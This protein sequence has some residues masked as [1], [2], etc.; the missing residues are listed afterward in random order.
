MAPP[1]PPE[2]SPEP[3][4]NRKSKSCDNDAP[5]LNGYVFHRVIKN[6]MIQAGGG[7]SNPG[8]CLTPTPTLVHRRL[9]HNEPF[10][11]SSASTTQFFVTTVKA[12]HLDGVHTV[13]GRLLSGKSVVRRIEH[14]P[15]GPWD[16]PLQRI[17]VA[18]CG[19]VPATK[20]WQDWIVN[21][22]TSD[23]YED[24]PE[25]ELTLKPEDGDG[26]LRIAKH[27]KDLGTRVYQNDTTPAA[28]KL[29]LTKYLKA[30]RYLHDFAPSSPAA[31]ICTEY[32]RLKTSLHLNTALLHTQLNQPGRA[33]RA[34]NAVLEPDHL[35]R[36]LTSGER[37]KALYRRAVALMKLRDWE[38]AVRDLETAR[39]IMPEDAMVQLELGKARRGVRLRRE[40]EKAAYGRFFRHLPKETS[41]I[42]K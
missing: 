27:V 28:K 40:G 37:A 42:S 17:V 11:L 19:Q 41:R 15:T 8:E 25:D 30:L 20:S 16:Q 9:K 24:Y 29:A 7:S 31:R 10:L 12:P 4:D 14:I 35:S 5:T 32:L 39:E 6:F 18:G 21:D 33:L 13:F 26:C 1:S 38:G 3:C 2:S 36:L 23:P 22:G 34:A